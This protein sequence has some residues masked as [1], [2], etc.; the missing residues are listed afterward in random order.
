[1]CRLVPEP[2]HS[3]MIV[4]LTSECVGHCRVFTCPLPLRIYEL[5][6]TPYNQLFILGIIYSI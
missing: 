6:P 2:Q 3:S 4:E 5:V 1:M